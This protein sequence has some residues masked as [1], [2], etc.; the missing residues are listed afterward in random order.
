MLCEISF[1]LPEEQLRNFSKEFD[2]SY[3]E[4]CELFEEK[5][6]WSLRHDISHQLILKNILYNITYQN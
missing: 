4:L 5:Q 1:L 2:M 6:R 3:D